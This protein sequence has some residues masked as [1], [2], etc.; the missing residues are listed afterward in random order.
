M[1]YFFNTSI[2]NASNNYK[3]NIINIKISPLILTC[4]RSP[5]PYKTQ[6]NSDGFT[7][8]QNLHPRRR[9]AVLK[10]KVLF[11]DWF[12]GSFMKENA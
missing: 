12:Y 4:Y 1:R 11:T 10:T 7:A 5:R 9:N 2:K 3:N 8:N 6:N